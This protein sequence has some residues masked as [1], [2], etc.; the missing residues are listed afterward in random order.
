MALSFETG[1]DDAVNESSLAL[2]QT[3]LTDLLVDKW[4]KL[5]EQES[6]IKQFSENKVDR[7][8]WHGIKSRS[9]DYAFILKS[10][11][12]SYKIPFLIA[13]QREVVIEP[14]A[15][16]I[17]PTQ[18][19]GK[20]IQSEG[21]PS[22]EIQI[23]GTCG[24]YPNQEG[25]KLPSSGVGSGLE[26][27]KFL[28]NVFRRYAYLKRFGNYKQ[29]LSL[30]YV[31]V[32]R[33]EAWVVEPKQFW[34]EDAIE[35]R[36]NFTY[37]ITLEALYP[38]DGKDA[39]GLLEALID[40]VP[41]LRSVLD[42]VQMVAETIDRINSLIGQI[43]A[44]YADFL[45]TVFR[46]LLQLGNILADIK[47]GQ[48]FGTSLQHFTR[49]VVK[50]LVNNL[51]ATAFTLERLGAPNGVVF[52]VFL[53][54]KAVERVLLI[55]KF[56]EPKPNNK[57]LMIEKAAS[58]AMAI[59][60]DPQGTAVSWI[61][62]IKKGAASKPPAIEKMLGSNRDGMKNATLPASG[63]GST[64]V[65][66][67]SSQTGVDATT[68]AAQKAK[69]EIDGLTSKK[70]AGL[71]SRISALEGSISRSV[72]QAIDNSK[73]SVTP[74][75]SALGKVANF[76]S[77]NTPGQDFAGSSLLPP[78][79]QSTI[80]AALWKDDFKASLKNID[81]A[82]ADYRVATVAAGDSIQTVA[83]KLLGDPARFVDL[84]LL[85]NLE[86]PYL[87]TKEY[88]AANGLKN[89]IAFG[90]SILFPTPKQSSKPVSVIKWRN[91]NDVSVILTPQERALGN[92]IL[93]DPVSRDIVF[94]A[95]DVS[96][97]YGK[98]NMSQFLQTLISMKRG[99][100]RRAISKGISEYNGISR[101]IVLPILQAE[102]SD[103]FSDDVRIRSVQTL[104]V[105]K[106]AQ[107]LLIKIAVFVRNYDDPIVITSRV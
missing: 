68:V 74:G 5:Y 21:S 46:P 32:K 99:H 3:L 1:V 47:T 64:L 33:Q 56:F 78:S 73:T 87:A 13:P 43:T 7:S 28:Q 29:D 18:G 4:S 59:F 69:D 83:K 11:G 25:A 48:I 98:D 12:L 62:G 44:L 17:T 85:N 102:I 2:V 66:S 41:G 45:D 16:T 93:L 76:S 26:G 67:G 50:S 15:M 89:V 63:T 37:N 39:K 61:E 81:S 105:Q 60:S 49:D 24:L 97:A 30:I 36:F 106:I 40:S 71:E 51:R 88:I 107:D 72:L 58:D 84:I 23:Q 86:Y 90:D 55:D 14:H 80:S 31:S 75:N 70:F 95:N 54:E 38:Y 6:D 42:I 101:D 96:L 10:G 94:G 77:S 65:G 20:L 9:E 57:A 27:F 91:E 8:K 35:H 79:T 52:A 100:W 22:K 82:N 92:D 53:A 34:S 104:S 19:G 103:L